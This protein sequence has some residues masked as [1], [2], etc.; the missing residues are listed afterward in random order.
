MT[1]MS[2]QQDE[3][4]YTEDISITGNIHQNETQSEPILEGLN[5]DESITDDIEG[6]RAEVL[7]SRSDTFHS[8][9]VSDRIDSFI[10][11]SN[12][13]SYSSYANRIRDGVSKD[14][15]CSTRI[16]EDAT[17]NDATE[18]SSKEGEERRDL[19]ELLETQ[20]N[21]ECDQNNISHGDECDETAKDE[22][23]N[24]SEE[25][26]ETV[27]QGPRSEDLETESQVNSSEE[28]VETE[29]QRPATEEE[30][31]TEN[32]TPATEEE[33]ETENQR[34][35]TEEELETENRRPAT[36]EEVE[37][38][39]QRPV[40]EDLETEFRR[41]AGLRNKKAERQGIRSEMKRQEPR[42]R[43]PFE[44]WMNILDLLDLRDVLN[45]AHVGDSTRKLVQLWA[46]WKYDSNGN[47]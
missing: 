46:H 8:V 5:A 41:P 26:L 27:S 9:D 34:P 4:Q 33:L 42:P 1:K 20:G 25:E 3:T 24:T 38:E 6:L 10:E 21:E 47:T 14:V 40:S 11:D 45:L 32:Q 22:R 12:D 7:D 18:N 44:L 23:C 39:N 13:L 15:M 36:E 16:E 2:T 30:L 31:E 17:E 37:T 29:N 28:E 43:I 35:A 19:S